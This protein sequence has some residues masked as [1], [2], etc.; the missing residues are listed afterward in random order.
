MVFIKEHI[1]GNVSTFIN[2]PDDA[3]DDIFALLLDSRKYDYRGFLIYLDKA[4]NTIINSSTEPYTNLLIEHD[5]KDI[6]RLL[7]QFICIKFFHTAAR[8]H[9]DGN[10]LIQQI[11]EYD[12]M[13]RFRFKEVPS[14]V[15]G[16]GLSK[17]AQ[18][19]K[20]DK[21]VAKA[22]L[23]FY[24]TI[25]DKYGSN[26]SLSPRVILNLSR[27]LQDDIKEVIQKEPYAIPIE[28][29]P[30]EQSI[31]L[32]NSSQYL[33]DVEKTKIS[34]DRSLAE[35]IEYVILLSCEGKKFAQSFNI[36]ELSRWTECGRFKK[37]I[38]V[39]F[40]KADGMYKLLR[41]IER[42]QFIYCSIPKFPDFKCYPILQEEIS[43]L[44]YKYI[45]TTPRVN[46]FGDD[47]S[48]FW[49]E[50]VAIADQYEGLYELRSF[51][52]MNIYSLV[53]NDEMKDFVLESLFRDNS[54][55]PR[56]LTEETMAVLDDLSQETR[57]AL[58]TT[59]DN[60]L[61]VMIDAGWC[62]YLRSKLNKQ[63]KVLISEYAKNNGL[64][65]SMFAIATGLDA[66]KQIT[67][68]S[69]IH[70]QHQGSALV[71]LDY[72][73]PGK[74][75][76]VL[77]PN[78]L[79]LPDCATTIECHFVKL[80]FKSK[81]D[82]SLYNYASDFI[83]ILDHS[84]RRNYLDIEGIW[85]EL[86]T[87]KPEGV[88]RTNWDI[89]NQYQY[90]R[91]TEFVRITF[92]SNRTRSYPT[93]EEFI[94]QIGSTGRLYVNKAVELIDLDT[95]DEIYVQ[96][97][98]EIHSDFNIY[99]KIAN[100]EREA[101]E[102]A[103]IRKRYS[104]S[105]EETAER[106]WKLLLR[107]EAD[108]IGVDQLYT[109]IQSYL[110]ANRT[111]LV[112]KTTFTDHWLNTNSATL[113]PREKRMFRLLCQY[114][115]L[116]STYFTI[117][118]R[119]K[120][121]AI[122]NSRQASKQMNRLLSDLINAG[123]FDTTT[124]ETHERLRQMKD[125]LSHNHRLHEFGFYEDTLVEDLNALIDLLRPNIKLDRVKEVELISYDKKEKSSA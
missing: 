55:K 2:N 117:M 112:S 14:Y 62:A 13:L 110:Q 59:L 8:S 69:S 124:P 30:K 98:D 111:D 10:Y 81:F 53:L 38:V 19:W 44:L 97:L 91:P 115:Q 70:L 73:D 87:T 28:R 92:D 108:T 106:L 37:L 109:A 31:I 32:L 89:E 43:L 65:L 71:I 33:S 20:Q 80:F 58:R 83:R 39:S 114:L 66:A 17:R 95:D 72:R 84:L 1:I 16:L 51:K 5:G 122:Q 121:A 107:R 21:A 23:H 18:K 22:L 29:I 47:H 123:C 90:S 86:K 85:K 74:F 12:R 24:Q 36:R 48:L 88:H 94:T 3:F 61:S 52:M 50:F 105:E 27:K 42:N 76:Y 64:L 60:A 101:R 56:L 35:V 82:W 9:R 49:E 67:T 6:L 79:E 54:N 75:P 11:H 45:K 104:L 40:S 25:A 120:N 41:H 34:D 78:I 102:L 63:C 15:R 103:V 7:L 96:M 119:L 113:I 100:K 68:W 99:E 57:H 125:E 77:K 4:L 26:T 116:P 46:F 118:L 93:S